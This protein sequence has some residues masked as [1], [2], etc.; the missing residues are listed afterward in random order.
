M[1]TAIALMVLGSLAVYLFFAF[2]NKGYIPKT[3]QMDIPYG[4]FTIRAVAQ[5]GKQFNINSGMVSRTDVAYSVLYDGKPVEFPNAVQNNTGLPFLWRV[6]ALTD[7]PDP[8][9]IAGSQSLFLIYLKD[10]KPVVEPLLNQ[11]HDFASLQFLDSEQG[12]PGAYTEVYA[13]S[14][15][16]KWQQIDSLKGGRLLM[17]GEHAVLDVKTRQLWYFNPN[18]EAVDNYSFP[19]PHGA[20]AFSPDRKSIVFRAEFQSWN[21]ENENLPASEHALVVYDYVSDKGYTVLFDDTET[22]MIR[23]DNA[24]YQWFEQYFEWLETP[25]GDRLQRRKLD[26]LPNWTGRYNPEDHFYTLYPVTPGILPVFLDFLM[27]ETGMTRAHIVKDETHEYTGH[28]LDFSKENI[29]LSVSFH[30]FDRKLTFSRNIYHE[31]N[32]DLEALVKSMAEKFDA[33]LASGKHQ[34]HFGLVIN[35]TRRIHGLE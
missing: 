28:C 16:D 14:D 25:E 9:L 10:Q 34:E 17:I 33:E 23:I 30:E 12:Q 21:T 15:L 7:A 11:Y 19:S 8:T 20:L 27:R 3:A 31:K 24:D 29:H 4:P 13:R 1:K 18:N 6:Y 26:K 5:T 2:R 32:Q 35:E 22:R